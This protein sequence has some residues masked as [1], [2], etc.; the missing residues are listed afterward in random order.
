VCCLLDPAASIEF[1]LSYGPSIVLDL[2][3]GLVC[4]TDRN[5]SWHVIK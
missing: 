3:I 5:T 2:S 1:L 4:V